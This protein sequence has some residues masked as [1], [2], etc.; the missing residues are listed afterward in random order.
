[1]FTFLGSHIV[2]KMYAAR[3]NDIWV[4]N[5]ITHEANISFM[6][7]A[8]LRLAQRANIRLDVRIQ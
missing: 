7:N 5:C 2:E 8:I 6:I 3:N 4:D 1:M